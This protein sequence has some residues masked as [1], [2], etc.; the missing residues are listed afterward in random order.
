MVRD[1]V[2]IVGEKVGLGKLEIGNSEV[3]TWKFELGT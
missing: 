3:R 1:Q 2:F